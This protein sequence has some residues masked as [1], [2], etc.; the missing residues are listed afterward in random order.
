MEI[1]E[2]Y[3]QGLSLA[4]RQQLLNNVADK[5]ATGTHFKALS[6]DEITEEM[7]DFADKNIEMWKLKN[8]LEEFKEKMKL[9]ME[10]LKKEISASLEVLRSK[11]LMVDE[12]LYYC[13]NHDEGYMEAYNL[14]GQLIEKRKLLPSEKQTGIKT[15]QFLKEA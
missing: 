3:L 6:E 5:I 4:D 7:R 15:T 13:A 1:T 9:S 10:P 2:K 14:S 11:G 8:E 12:E